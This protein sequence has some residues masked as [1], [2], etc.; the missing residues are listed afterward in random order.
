MLPGMMPN[1][2]SAVLIAPTRDPH[3]CTEMV[4]TAQI[5]CVTA[6]LTVLLVLRKSRRIEPVGRIHPNIAEIHRFEMHGVKRLG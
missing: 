4:L 2:P 5:L 1:P 6:A 3:R